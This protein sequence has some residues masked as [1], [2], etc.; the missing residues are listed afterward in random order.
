MKLEFIN[1]GSINSAI[2]MLAVTMMLLPSEAWTDE[3]VDKAINL[4]QAEVQYFS[5]KTG[6]VDKVVFP[7]D[8]HLKDRPNSFL[9]E[10]KND[11]KAGVHLISGKKRALD[12]RCH[13]QKASAHAFYVEINGKLIETQDGKFDIPAGK[14]GDYINGLGDKEY[15]LSRKNGT[16]AHWPNDIEKLCR[17]FYQYKRLIHEYSKKGDKDGLSQLQGEF[18]ATNQ[19]LNQYHPDD[20]QTMFS[21][22]MQ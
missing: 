1:F 8:Y 5:L 19:W 2:I 20:V 13:I 7:N 18:D 12:V 6:K 10:Y 22:L 9:I 14:L 4:C 15:Y 16:I 17:D 21:F 11:L 3:E